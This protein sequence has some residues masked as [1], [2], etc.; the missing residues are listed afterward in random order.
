MQHKQFN[1]EEKLVSNRSSAVEMGTVDEGAMSSK[2]ITD[3]QNLILQKKNEV[4]K[5]LLQSMTKQKNV[6]LEPIYITLFLIVFIGGSI[7]IFALFL[8][9]FLYVTCAA[10]TQTTQPYWTNSLYATTYNNPPLGLYTC[11]SFFSASITE[12]AQLSQATKKPT[13]APT[14]APMPS[15]PSPPVSAPTIPVPKNTGFCLVPCVLPG[16]DCSTQYN[17]FNPSACSAAI[18]PDLAT[19]YGNFTDFSCSIADPISCTTQTGPGGVKYND[20]PAQITVV[21]LQC[22]STAQSFL[23]AV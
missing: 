13:S 5:Q 21:Y 23:N 19:Y 18:A 22:T 8:Y 15:A 20:V 1:M 2:S 4:G 6:D 12:C 16:F 14:V 17:K 11:Q 9:Y 3:L 10:K 7:I